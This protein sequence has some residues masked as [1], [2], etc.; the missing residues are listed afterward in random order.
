MSDN[1]SDSITSNTELASNSRGIPSAEFINEVSSYIIS[2]ST[3]ADNLL[4]SLHNLYGRYKF[5]E[6]QLISQQKQ[7]LTKIPDISNALAAVEYLISK[8]NTKTSCNFELCD[9]LFA[10]ATIDNN[11][12]RVLLW[13]GANVMLEYNYTEARDLLIKNKHNAEINLKS[14]DIDL[15]FLKDQITISEVNIARV[16]N[17]KVTLKQQQNAMNNTTITNSNEIQSRKELTNKEI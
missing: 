12:N 3:T 6:S 8:P 5:M 9:S 17:Y 7:L 14:L 15:A 4:K 16:H 2:K 10:S 13:L 11:T 1:K